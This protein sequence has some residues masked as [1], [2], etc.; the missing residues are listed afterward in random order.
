MKRIISQSHR[1]ARHQV[2]SLEKQ[3]VR[4]PDIRRSIL[5]GRNSMDKIRIAVL[6][7]GNMGTRHLNILRTFEDVEVAAICSHTPASGEKYNAAQNTDYPVYTDFDEMLEKEAI[8]ALWVCLP[9]FGHTG[10]IEKAA[11]KG[12]HIFTEKP[13][14]LNLER[15]GSIA[16][17][18]RDNHVLSQVGYHMRFGKA[19]R[20]LRELME[21]GTA[22]KPSL[23]SASYE[24][25]SLHVDWWRDKNKSGGQIFEQII[26]LYDMAYY[27]M[28]EPD[29]V[30]GFIA[31]ICHQDVPGYTVEDTSAV[32]IR[33]KNGTLGSITASNNAI[34]NRWAGIMKIIFENLV[35]ELSDHNNGRFVYT[36]EDC[37]TEEIHSD[38]DT[39]LFEEDRYFLDV[40]HG[41]KEPFAT[42]EDGLTGLK[43]VSGACTASENGGYPVRISGN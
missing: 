22:G 12:I 38:T 37:R 3:S 27:V 25:N 6:G 41:K 1:E 4:K 24:C 15:G 19:V 35:V 36:K 8:D 40:I 13:I 14:A 9:P 39:A 2:K 34:P 43:I 16:A 29:T 33:F 5:K 31:N 17:A 18:I 21:N 23:F 42:I 7:M 28:G 32:S 11:A 26:H 30:T 20:H 10:Q